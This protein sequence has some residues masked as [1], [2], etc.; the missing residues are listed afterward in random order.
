M[1]SSPFLTYKFDNGCV[2]SLRASGTEPKLKFYCEL[3]ST[4]SVAAARAELDDFV[5]RVVKRELLGQQ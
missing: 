4:D 1:S 3:V 5:E 2:V